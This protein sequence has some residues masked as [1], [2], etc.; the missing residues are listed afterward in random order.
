MPDQVPCGRFSFRQQLPGLR[1]FEAATLAISPGSLL[2]AMIAVLLLNFSDGVVNRL[3][4]P[5]QRPPVTGL[6]FGSVSPKVFG[7]VF[8]KVSEV[9][10]VLVPLKPCFDPLLRPWFSMTEPTTTLLFAHGSGRRLNALIRF[11]IA[12][13]VWSLFGTILCRQSATRF[14]GQD[15]SSIRLAIHYGFARWRAS[16]AAPLIPLFTALLLG[17]FAAMWGLFGRLPILGSWWLTLTSPFL[18]FLGLLMA[19]LL[20][21]T[22]LGWPL[23]VAAVATDDCDS[24]GGLSR[25]W[26]GLL[27]RPW[28][29][30]AYV[31]MALMIGLM[32]M[33][34]AHLFASTASYCGVSSTAFGSGT[35]QAKLGLIKPLARLMKLMLAG[36]GVSYFWSTST[37]LFLL[38]RQEIDGL[39]LNHLARDIG[40]RPVRDPLPVVG[41]PATDAEINSNNGLGTSNP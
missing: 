16:C 24:Y 33:L 31:I 15:E 35:S 17:L 12:T 22:A 29:F 14:A 19:L 1:L 13:V 4:S 27:N 25:A 6:L 39:P 10:E 30:L 7:S 37:I 28:H 38:L 5:D 36:V 32:L 41:I 3:F 26:G 2:F 20:L 21:T 23:M 40:D 9:L 34:V 8:P 18:G 11:L